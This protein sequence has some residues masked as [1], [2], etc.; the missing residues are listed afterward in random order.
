MN[1]LLDTDICSAHLKRP[2]GLMHR[3]MQHSGGLC[4]S[5]ITLGELCTWAFKRPDSSESIRRIENEL[6]PDLTLLDF[7][8]AC[9]YQFG[10]VRAELLKVGISVS[11]ADLLIA[12]VALTHDLTMVTHNIADYRNIPGLRLE[13][14]LAP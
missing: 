7:N 3:F 4:I 10:K 6:L 13:D 1:F 12:S 2:A 5:S 14:W 11:R 9:A 8:S